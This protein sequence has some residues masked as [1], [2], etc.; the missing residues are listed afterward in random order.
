MAQGILTPLQLTAAAS[1]LNNQGI[2]ALPTALTDALTALNATTLFTNFSAAV[3]D[4]VAESFANQSTLDLL[5]AIGNTDCPALGNSVPAA[6]T[7]LVYTTVA[8]YGFSGLI[9]QTG[10][11]YLGN[12]DVSKFCTGF[13]AV[14][15]YRNTVNQYINSAVN[16]QTYLGPT[17]VNMDALVT[18]N[19]SEINPA[20]DNFATDLYQQGLLWNPANMVYYGTPAGLLQ[21]LAEVGQFRV[22]FFGSLQTSLIA[23]GLTSTDIQQLISGQEQLTSTQ[24]NTLQQLAYLAMKEVNGDTLDQVLDILNITLPNI[25][26]M[27]DLLNP[28][29]IF[30]LSYSTLQVPA[31]ATWQPIFNPDTSVNLALAPV[32]NAVLPTA[33]GCDELAKVI[34]PDQAVANKAIQLSLQQITGLP[35]TTVPALAQTIRGLADRIWSPSI[36]YLANDVVAW[37]PGVPVNYQ[38]QQNVPTG[39]DISNTAYWLPTDLGGLSTMADLPL[40]QAQTTPIAS[41][42]A[43]YFN[44]N[45]GTGTGPNGTITVCDVIGLAIDNPDFAAQLNIAVTNINSLQT[46]GALTALNTA[47]TSIVS[48]INDAAVLTQITNAN[49]AIAAIVAN[50]TYATQVAALND[51]WSAMADILSQEKTYQTRASIDYFNILSDSQTTV[52]SFVQQLPQYGLETEACGACYFLEQVADTTTL[53]GQAIVGTMREGQNNQRLSQSQL[54]Q[55]TAPSSEPVVTPIPVI[56]PV[57]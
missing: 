10:N 47:Y 15:G 40:I 45:Q 30:P 20:F 22:E 37:G 56:T 14:Q 11:A 4:Y 7:N 28:I 43:T 23:Q 27:A 31:G 19:I 18:N 34:P 50:P 8:P 24:F 48:A 13:M 42:V 16:A 57:Y 46:V 44:N 1:L 39:I 6:V 29:K 41:S 3:A 32:L 51:A 9:E 35:L 5:L 36:S 26:T 25:S 33:S 2:N 38:A 55:D 12:G 17:F 49:A 52:M 54:S 21:Q 53:G